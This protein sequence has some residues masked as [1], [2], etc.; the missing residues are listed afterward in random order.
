MFNLLRAGRFAVVPAA[1]GI[2]GLAGY[3]SAQQ[4][5]PQCAEKLQR[6]SS[7][8]SVSGKSE[9]LT[10]DNTMLFT[11]Y[12]KRFGNQKKV[13]L[14][15]KDVCTLLE[16]VGINCADLNKRIFRCMDADKGGT[17]DIKEM[18]K[19]CQML[20]CGTSDQKAQFMFDA[21]DLDQDGELDCEEMRTVVKEMMLLCVSMYPAFSL[22]NTEKDA[23][24]MAHLSNEDVAQFETNRIVYD[25]FI[26][27][28]RSGSGVINLKEFLYWYKRGGKTVNEFRNLFP[29]F[30]VLIKPQDE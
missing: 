17:V 8:R 13:E 9:K 23:E 30:D 4:Q 12:S 22:I 24:L 7:F 6:N 16:E 21:C 11:C 29:I 27:A 2:A 14:T 1:A 26:S 20:A 15:E 28:G 5:G 10:V 19:F 18:K 25:M 3:S